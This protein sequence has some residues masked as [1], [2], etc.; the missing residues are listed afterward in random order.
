MLLELTKRHQTTVLCLIVLLGLFLRL[1]GLD[2]MGFNDDEIHKVEAARSYRHGNFLVN[3]EHPMLM[4]SLVTLS[5]AAADSWN[6]GPG[7]S[8][9]V[10]DEVA[11]R[12]PNVIFWSL[13]VV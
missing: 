2:S 1:R 6:R 11:V 8:Y 12:L 4:K 5:L 9:Q 10:H 13:T 3:L 7:R